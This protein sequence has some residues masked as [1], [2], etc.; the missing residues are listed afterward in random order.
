MRGLEDPDYEDDVDTMETEER[1]ETGILTFRPKNPDAELKVQK[2]KEAA[3]DAMEMEDT[4]ILTFRP[5]HHNVQREGPK[6]QEAA[7]DAM[8]MDQGVLT[9]RP[10]QS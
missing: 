3:V 1:E 10:K 9:F 8:E 5:N 4:G 7:V 6:D 2:Y